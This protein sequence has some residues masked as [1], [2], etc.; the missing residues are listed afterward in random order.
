[1][2]RRQSRAQRVANGA[3]WLDENFPGW[4]ERIDIKTLNLASGNSCI[5]GQVFY[6]KRRTNG[7]YSYA[8]EHLF[9]QANGWLTVMV[10]KQRF[11][12]DRAILVSNTL[13]FSTNTNGHHGDYDWQEREW[14]GL[15][16]EWKKL[17][18]QRQAELV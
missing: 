15:E 18:R 17:L 1:M 3:R 10:P 8:L 2:A 11:K 16:R 4:V 9:A 14:G 6:S 7:G 5:C 12:R 13:G